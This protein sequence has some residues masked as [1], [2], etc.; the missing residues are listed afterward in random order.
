M[1]PI[2]QLGISP[3]ELEELLAGGRWAEWCASEPVLNE[4]AGLGELRGL[5]GEY[6]DRFLG[7]LVRL[8]SQTG[9]DDP[10]AAIAVTHQLCGSIRS[11]ARRFWWMTDEDIEGIVTATMWAEVRSFEWRRH[12]EHYGGKLT[13]ATRRAVRRLLT[14]G[15]SGYVDGAVVPVDPQTW[16]FGALAEHAARESAVAPAPDARQELSHFLTWA[17]KQG[18]LHDD[19]VTL[20]LSLVAIDCDNPTITKW[21]RGACSVTA[22]AQVAEQ[23]GVCAKSVSRARD[24]A[25]ER[26]RAVAPAY[27]QEVA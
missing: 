14:T 4:I 21:M 13:Y 16:T 11:I 24:R 7:A 18:H 17:T 2:R 12:T 3:D 20:L 23:R 15:H 26:L 6:E 25:L 10:T 8:A 9:G 19:D 1:P 27:L 5:R 22:V